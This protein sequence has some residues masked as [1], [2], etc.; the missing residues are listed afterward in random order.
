MCGVSLMVGT[1]RSTASPGARGATGRAPL[2]P[3][4]LALGAVL[5]ATLVLA[6]ITPQLL[7]IERLAEATRADVIPEM[8]VAQKRAIWTESL[9]S[10]ADLVVYAPDPEV[11]RDALT[12]AEQLASEL[13]RNRDLE[14]RAALSQGLAAIRTAAE[15]TEE[16]ARLE[17]EIETLLAE[18]GDAIGNMRTSLGAITDDA[19]GTLARLLDPVP[20]QEHD[21]RAR[22]QNLEHVLAVSAASQDLL[23]HAERGRGLLTTVGSMESGDALRETSERFRAVGQHLRSRV[24]TLRGSVGYQH[25]AETVDRFAGL[26]AVFDRQQTVLEVREQALEAS[27]EAKLRLAALRESLAADA[28]D[29]AEGTVASIAEGSRGIKNMALVAVGAGALVVAGAG[30]YARQR[31][32]VLQDVPPAASGPSDEER[33]RREHLARIAELT[34]NYQQAQ[35][36]LDYWRDFL[37]P[38]LY[39]TVAAVLRGSP[40][41]DEQPDMEA[42]FA[43]VAEVRAPVDDAPPALPD[44]LPELIDGIGDELWSVAARASDAG[45]RA[46]ADCMAAAARTASKADEQT[47]PGSVPALP[48]EVDLESPLLSLQATVEAIERVVAQ[49]GLCLSAINALAVASSASDPPAETTAPEPQC[50]GDRLQDLFEELVVARERLGTKA[51][52]LG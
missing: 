2:R 46:V 39:R 47:T 3:R 43:A 13:L 24:S 51:R 50:A 38:K 45:L 29:T 41:E 33:A 25:L 8:V 23:A 20:D 18:A 44:P 40:T 4:R 35:G 26:A 19:A 16:G 31:A 11:R 37:A 48:P 17:R 42:P 30:A 12:K 49:I 21:Q 34:R 5:L 27:R 14:R 36:N 15:A 28:A 10:A 52:E 7:G 32:R 1:R 9:R 22:R 6:V